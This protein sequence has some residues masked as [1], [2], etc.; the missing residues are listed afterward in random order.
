LNSYLS[1]APLRHCS[2]VLE[3]AEASE[4]IDYGMIAYRFMG[5]GF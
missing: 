5:Q 1:P 2:G 3:P 4:Y